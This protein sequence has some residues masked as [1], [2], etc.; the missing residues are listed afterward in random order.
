M[1][2]VLSF[3]ADGLANIMTGRGTSVDR[4][5]HNIWVNQYWTGDTILAA[6][7][8]SWLHRKIATIPAQDMTRAG[9]DWDADDKEIAAIEAEEKRLGYWAKVREAKLLGNLGGGAILI[10]LGDDP[11]LPLPT[12]IRPGQVQYLTVLSRYELKL[13]DMDMD[14]RSL[15]FRQ[16]SKFM[17]TG[18]GKQVDIHPSRIVCFHGLPLPAISPSTSWEDRFWGDS[19]VQVVDEAV[20]QAT[21]AAT[22]FASL[23]DEAKIDIFKFSQMAETLAGDNGEA[24]LM[25]R[26]QLTQ[27]GKSVHRAVILDKDDDWEQR[28]IAWSGMRDVIITYD[29]RVAGAADIPATRLFGKAPD[30]MNATGDGDM[31]NYHQSIGARQE[32]ELRPAME[33]LD[34]VVLPSAGVKTDLSWKF[35]TLTVLTEQQE[36][37]IEAKESESI[38]KIVATGLIPESALSKSYQGRLIESQRW[39]DL[40]DLIEE[41]EAA[42]EELPGDPADLGIVPIPGTLNGGKEVD[43]NLAGEGGVVPKSPARR[44]ANDAR[45]SDATPRTLYVSR[46]VVNVGDLKAWAKKQGLPELQDDLHVTLIYSRQPLDWMKVDAEDWNQKDD[47]SIEIPP[48]GVRIVEPLG[49]RSAVLLFTSSRLSWRH[50]QIVRAGAEHGFPDYQPHISLTGEAV[51]LAGVE[52]YRGKIVLGP[53]IFEEVRSEGE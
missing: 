29:G 2:K 26:V 24:K 42:G 3:M 4:A 34:A 5:A 46:P 20:A 45:F 16:P 35:S 10:G 18:G 13:G 9:R 17:L 11:A 30:G 8:S 28:Q 21:T 53:E 6:F 23:I 32:M 39:P 7:R 25:K 22:G 41:A 43:P 50:E 38:T 27:Q 47:G 48:G 15:F 12:T 14:P 52:P 51:D 19:V 37:E 36:A 44:A 49:D 31:A 40:K 1:G 33:A